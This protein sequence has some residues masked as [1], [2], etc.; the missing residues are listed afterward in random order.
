MAVVAGMPANLEYI[1][2]LGLALAPAGRTEEARGV[3]NSSLRE[4]DNLRPLWGYAPFE[5]LLEARD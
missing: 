2:Y 3:T 1:G 4:N 5:A